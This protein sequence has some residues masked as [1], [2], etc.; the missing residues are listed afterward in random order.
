M[1]DDAGEIVPGE[2]WLDIAG[3]RIEAHGGGMRA[4]RPSLLLVR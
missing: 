2:P 4:G 1:F 3:E